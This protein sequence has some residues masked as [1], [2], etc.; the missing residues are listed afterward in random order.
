MSILTNESSSA[1]VC[2]VL[3]AHE[4]SES[5][6]HNVDVSMS[7]IAST[8]LLDFLLAFLINLVD[9]LSLLKSCHVADDFSTKPLFLLRLLCLSLSN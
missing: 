5:V 8:A 7:L 4:V 9:K 2:V 3:E 1:R 6:R